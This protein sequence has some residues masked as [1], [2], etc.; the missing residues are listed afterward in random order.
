MGIIHIAFQ[1]TVNSAWK[2]ELGFLSLKTTV[3]GSGAVISA[4]LICTGA[5]QRRPLVF[6]WVW[7]V[8]TTSSAVNSTPSLQKMPLRSFTVISVKS[9]L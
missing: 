5:L 7:M 6:M 8:K 3:C 2:R 1:R 4:T 9:A